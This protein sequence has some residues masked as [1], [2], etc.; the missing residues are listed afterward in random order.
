M[1]KGHVPLC[2]EIK[3]QILTCDHL[4]SHKDTLPLIDTAELTRPKQSS[5]HDQALGGKVLE[6]DQVVVAVG[7]QTF[8]GSEIPERDVALRRIPE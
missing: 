4:L 8:F 5:L 7:Q 3:D 1:G 6:D 2:V